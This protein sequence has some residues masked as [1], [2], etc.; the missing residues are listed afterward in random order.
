MSKLNWRS[1]HRVRRALRGDR[2]SCGCIVGVYE[3]YSGAVLSVIDVRAPAC[4]DRS[5][6]P[7]I[8]LPPEDERTTGQRDDD[9]AG[10]HACRHP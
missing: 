5:H 10:H 8:V 6:E 2:L 3:L 9:D 4:R 7:H 1:H